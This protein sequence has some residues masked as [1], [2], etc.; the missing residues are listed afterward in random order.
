M[1]NQLGPSLRTDHHPPPNHQ[2]S[3][4]L[5]DMRSTDRTNEYMNN[6]GTNTSP[7]HTQGDQSND[8]TQPPTAPTDRPTDRRRKINQCNDQPIERS[9]HSPTIETNQ[10]KQPDGRPTKKEGRPRTERSKPPTNCRSNE[11][12]TNDPTDRQTDDEPSDRAEPINRTDRPNSP[13]DATKDDPNATETRSGPNHSRTMLPIRTIEPDR[14]NEGMKQQND[15]QQQ[16]ATKR[17]RTTDGLARQA[18]N[19]CNASKATGNTEDSKQG[20][21]EARNKTWEQLPS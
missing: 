11:E 15:N 20:K 19:P 4:E 14:P 10:S 12:Q 9:D 13:I 21:Q 7:S 3:I 18:S 6:K 5:P 16:K 8:P 1:I 2:R 17:E